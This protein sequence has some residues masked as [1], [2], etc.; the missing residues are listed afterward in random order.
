MPNA[1][2]TPEHHQVGSSCMSWPAEME[3][4]LIVERTRAG[5]DVGRQL[6]GKGGRKRQMTDSKIV[7]AKKLLVSGVPPKDV[8][9]PLGSSIGARL[10]YDFFR[11]L[12]RP[13]PVLNSSRD[14]GE[15]VIHFLSMDAVAIR[16]ATLRL[17][18]GAALVSGAIPTPSQL[19]LVTGF[20]FL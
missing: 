2:S 9:V 16:I 7:S 15:L 4:E 1:L 5:L 14:R 12:R 3:R 6:G 13:L 11:F 10:A 17:S 20:T 19:D 18:S 8:A